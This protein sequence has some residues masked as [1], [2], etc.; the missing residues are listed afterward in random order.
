[1]T[2][3][4]P[5]PTGYATAT[6][7]TL[8]ASGAGSAS[9]RA[10]HRRLGRRTR[11]PAT[12]RLVALGP[13]LRVRRREPLPPPAPAHLAMGDA[14]SHPRSGP[15]P[16][17]RAVQPCSSGESSRTRHGGGVDRHA[18]R[19]KVAQRSVA[20]PAR[21][22]RDQHRE[23]GKGRAGGLHRQPVFRRHLQAGGIPGSGAPS[24]RRAENVVV[25]LVPDRNVEGRAR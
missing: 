14:P 20:L 24:S 16:Q 2:S 4:A 6:T 15:P 1:M 17:R 7:G 5:N 13:Q 11:G 22:G 19:A 23:D 12:A 21:P 10:A 8:P 3:D 25:A 18:A 9:H